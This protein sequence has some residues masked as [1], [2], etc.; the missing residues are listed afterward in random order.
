MARIKPRKERR[1]ALKKKRLAH[2]A[3]EPKKAPEPELK[4]EPAKELK[5]KSKPGPKPRKKEVELIKPKDN[6]A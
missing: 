6:K 5:T 3:P 4:P 2:K 1:M